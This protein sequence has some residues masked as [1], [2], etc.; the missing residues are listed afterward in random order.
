MAD[1]KI[2]KGLNVPSFSRN[3]ALDIAF[4][5]LSQ[6][7]EINDSLDI[8]QDALTQ[9]YNK[10]TTE[11]KDQDNYAKMKAVL[12]ASFQH[13]HHIQ[14]LSI[15][16]QNNKPNP[17]VSTKT[18]SDQSNVI[19]ISLH[20]MNHLNNL[21]NIIV[22]QLIYPCLLKGSYIP[23]DQRRLKSFTEERKVFKF[24]QL[25]NM[26][27]SLDI[28]T[29]VIAQFKTVFS[30]SGDVRD[31]MLKGSGLTDILT[32]L[33]V[34]QQM[35]IPVDQDLQLFESYS[36]S[37]NLFGIYITLLQSV[38]IPTLKPAIINRLTS[39]LTSRPNGLISLIDFIMG[40]RDEEEI[41]IEN[42]N[43]VNMILLSK[44]KSMSSMEYYTK[45]FGQVYE[46]L[47][48]INRP[49]LV[50]CVIN[51]LKVLYGKNKR[52]LQ[53]FLFQ[54]I[55]ACLCPESKVKAESD[56][57]V[58]GKNLN[59]AVNVLISLTKES[60]CDLLADLFQSSSSPLTINLWA[61]Y[62]YLS[63]RNSEYQKVIESVLISYFTTTMDHSALEVMVL[64]LARSE[65][66]VGVFK[67]D[68]ETGLTSIAKADPLKPGMSNDS[69]LDEIDLGVK[70]MVSLL[71]Q[72]PE[73]MIRVQFITVLNRW[74][75][76]SSDVKIEDTNKLDSA[77]ETNPFLMLIDLKL[78]E[79]L[80]EHFKE[81]LMDKPHD[82]LVVL[83]SLLETK[84]LEDSSSVRIDQQ[85]PDSDDEDEDTNEE[86]ANANTS[87]TL[88]ILLEL[89]SAILSETNPDEL[90]K[91]STI[92]TEISQILSLNKSNKQCQSLSFRIQT[93]LNESNNDSTAQSR[94][95]R[96]QYEK[97]QS[98]FKTAIHNLN[99]PLVPIRAHGLYLL[100]QLI[101]RK[102]EVITL[103][104][105][106]NLHLVQLKD[107]DPFIYLN[108]IKSLNELIDFDED[109]SMSVLIEL[110]S[111][112]AEQSS[113]ADLDER[114]KIGEVLLNYITTKNELLSG[115]LIDS[116][117]VS[118]LNI[119][120][121]VDK[122]D[123]RLRMSAM[124]LLG[125][126]LRTNALSLNRFIS[127]SL[128]VSIGILEF[129]KDI[130]MLRSSIVLISDLL[131]FGGLEIFPKG[132][133][134][135]LH[136]IL[137]FVR[138]SYQKEDLLLIEMIDKVNSIVGELIKEK[139]QIEDSA[140]GQFKHMKINIK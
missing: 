100:R 4:D 11:G 77:E 125:H 28:L 96:S 127:D 65:L 120:R 112:K 89:L 39:I 136:T 72:L 111:N 27:Q 107:Q 93:F 128:D 92:L 21:L 18:D 68:L 86:G 45:I 8:S 133:A 84:M 12:Q 23:L 90:L 15:A 44:P 55:R 3:T 140:S 129:E 94:M 9:L 34:L 115:E 54:R 33:M 26:E 29:L 121:A 82:L 139:F 106:I 35:K 132:Y 64:N 17:T 74:I 56:T 116:M 124:S 46:V 31:L 20:D 135:K 81:I 88:G 91:Q 53:D 52:I 134:R 7:I 19:S 40:I 79:V 99:D 32:T 131:A 14:D 104:F 87:G 101:Q 6:F 42:F 63:K 98:Q 118:I 2:K 137:G 95:R 69:V 5:K 59:N 70:L 58:S 51:Y 36:D 61:Y 38:E 13:L 41:N 73:D 108:V 80:N 50:S 78:I 10:C 49:V 25:R 97:D 16:K 24:Q 60:S 117:I 123:N 47:V 110:Y 62:L 75:L 57:V 76:K 22:S 113:A 102:S 71:K 119:I 122:E 30:K 126:S 114:L 1:N 37:Y 103:D 130:P 48:M 43:Q 138:A 105:A 109:G 66:D 85:E 67:T 83:K